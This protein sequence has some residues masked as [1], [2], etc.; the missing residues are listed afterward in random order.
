VDKVAAWIR[1]TAHGTISPAA[2]DA[3]L[4]FLLDI[5]LS[6]LASPPDAYREYVAAVRREYGH[7]P[8]DQFRAGRARVLRHFLDRPALYITPSLHA[9]WE[10]AARSN[11]AAELAV[12]DNDDGSRRP[13]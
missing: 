13:S 12:L 8:E 10:N 9:V 2:S 4:A 5:D 7:V 3:D 1:A 11:L 6:I